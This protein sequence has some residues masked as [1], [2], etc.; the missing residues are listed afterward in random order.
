MARLIAPVF[1]FLII[2][3][4]SYS[5]TNSSMQQQINSTAAYIQTVN[6]SGYLIFYPNLSQSYALLAKAQNES[7]SNPSQS[8]SL[9]TMARQSADQQLQIIDSYRNTAAVIV[10]IFVIVIGT[11][12]Y[13]TMIPYRRRN[14]RKRARR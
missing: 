8:L 12:L 13:Y 10:A 2:V 14:T 3:S 11:L 9:L 6:E 1:Y 5:Q 7:T 4:V